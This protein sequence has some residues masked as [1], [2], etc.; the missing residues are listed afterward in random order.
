MQCPVPGQI[1]PVGVYFV[2]RIEKH[3][4]NRL[5]YLIIGNFSFFNERKQVIRTT[6]RYAKNFFDSKENDRNVEN[7]SCSASNLPL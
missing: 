7:G 3:F 1:I 6:T 2:K 4:G 5:T